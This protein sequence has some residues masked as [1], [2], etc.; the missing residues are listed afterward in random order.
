MDEEGTPDP[1]SFKILYSRCFIL[2]LQK[3]QFYLKLFNGE[4]NSIRKLAY[5]AGVEV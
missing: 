4:F 2:F 3:R 5:R 1:P